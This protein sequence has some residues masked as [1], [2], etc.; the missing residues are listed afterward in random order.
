MKRT[1]GI[2]IV[3]FTAFLG[4]KVASADTYTEVLVGPDVYSGQTTQSRVTNLTSS[5]YSTIKGSRT[6]FWIVNAGWLRSN[7]CVADSSREAIVKM[8]EDDVYPNADDL[9]KTYTF[10]FNGRQLVA[11]NA[12]VVTNNPNNADSSG[13]PTVELFL[14]NYISPISGDRSD[15]NGELFTYQFSV[16]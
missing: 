7:V 10:S 12:N 5:V 14:T 13:D 16:A 11:A 15:S 1:L 2:M 6:Y 9:L 4:I 8:Y 3:V